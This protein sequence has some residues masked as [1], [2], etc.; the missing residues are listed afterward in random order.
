MSMVLLLLLLL[1]LLLQATA[2]RMQ[3]NL[4]L[5]CHRHKA[6]QPIFGL[7]HRSVL[8]SHL[9]CGQVG[10]NQQGD[11]LD[12]DVAFWEQLAGLCLAP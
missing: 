8:A 12:R 1:L 7:T 5:F 6:Q 10:P 11:L 4:Q 3:W 9:V 2:S